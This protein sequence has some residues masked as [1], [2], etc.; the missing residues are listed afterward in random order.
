MNIEE[1]KNLIRRKWKTSD[2][3]KINGFSFCTE[4]CFILF[5]PDNLIILNEGGFTEVANIKMK[6]INSLI[7]DEKEML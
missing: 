6:D 7:I 5:T 4:E 1:F 2:Y 3:I